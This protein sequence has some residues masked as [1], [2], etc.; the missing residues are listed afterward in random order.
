MSEG[1]EAGQLGCSVDAFTILA[2][3]QLFDE[4]SKEREMVSQPN[5]NDIEP[6]LNG[7]Q[8]R[9]YNV[10]LSVRLVRIQIVSA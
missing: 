2:L 5:L 3:E 9:H 6:V 7:E 4:W 10:A 8:L 1:G